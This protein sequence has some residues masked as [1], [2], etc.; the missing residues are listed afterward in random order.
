MAMG[1]RSHRKKE[2]IAG[3]N[4]LSTRQGGNLKQ[5]PEVDARCIRGELPAHLLE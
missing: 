2:N 4:W 3:T 5:N 1:Q